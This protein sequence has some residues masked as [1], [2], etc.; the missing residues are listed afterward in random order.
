MVEYVYGC[1]R[2]YLCVSVWGGLCLCACDKCVPSGDP[3]QRSVAGLRW[4]SGQGV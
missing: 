2:V 3:L 4:L 1:T